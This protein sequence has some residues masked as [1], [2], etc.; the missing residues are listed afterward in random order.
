MSARFGRNKRRRARQQIEALQAKATEDAVAIIKMDNW[1]AQ[2]RGLLEHVGRQRDALQDQ[3]DTAR[4]MLPEGSVLF[5][6]RAV[7]HGGR[8]G[9]AVLLERSELVSLE[10]I[11]SIDAISKRSVRAEPLETIIARIRPDEIEGRVHAII[12]YADGSKAYGITREVIESTSREGLVELMMRN[13]APMLV[14]AFVDDVLKP[15]RIRV[16]RWA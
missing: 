9:D 8:P 7:R 1:V 3:V 6:P 2:T 11:G 13:F 12:D 10:P 16:G 14:K 4:M 15:G 5:E